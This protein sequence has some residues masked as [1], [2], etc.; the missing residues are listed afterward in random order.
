MIALVGLV[1]VLVGFVMHGSYLLGFSLGTTFREHHEADSEG[2]HARRAMWDMTRDA[3][4]AMA[5][6]NA[7]ATD[8]ERRQDT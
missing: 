2:A 8:E 7:A 3:F 4:A 1:V 5:E 6:T